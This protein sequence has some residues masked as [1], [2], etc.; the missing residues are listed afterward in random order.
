M[1]ATPGVS[2]SH[3]SCTAGEAA[4]VLG[5][6]IRQVKNPTVSGKLGAVW[7]LYLNIIG[8]P[9][10]NEECEKHTDNIF[11]AVSCGFCLIARKQE[12]AWFGPENRDS[13]KG[14]KI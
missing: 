8:P 3:C 9:T 12:S 6:L 13:S 2:P 1:W 10:G 11:L 7:I 4:P 14:D 5:S